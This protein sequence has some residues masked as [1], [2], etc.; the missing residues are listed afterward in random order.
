MDAHAP[1]PGGAV[2]PDAVRRKV[3]WRILPFV[4]LLYIV[5]YLDRANA[6]FAKLR[7]AAD[8]RFSEE[9][10]GL[11]F[12]IF[13]IG[14]LLLEIPGALIVERWSARKWFVRILI[15]W[16]CMSAATAFVR[17]P[18]EFY[19]ARFFLGVA[20]AGFFPGIIVHFTHWF[21][22]RDRSRALSG[23]ILGVPFSLALGAP[24]SG[25]LLGVNWL[26]L[27]GW[28]WMFIVEGAPAVVL[29][30]ATLFLLT[31]RP[32]DAAWL[33]PGE[34]EW[35]QTALDEEARA[36]ESAIRVTLWDALR[37]PQVWL[38]T[39]AIFATNTGGYAMA[40]WLPTA[41]KGVSG[42][43]DSQVLLWT[44]M[45]YS[46]GLLSV[47]LSGYSS[48]RTGE[49]KWHC[50]AGQAATAVFLSLSAIPGQPFPLVMV[51][52]CLTGFAA[53][54]WP[55]PF[56]SLPTLTLT[57]GAAAVALGLI[58]MGANLAGYLGNRNVGWLRSHGFDDRACLLFLAGCY[59]AGGILVSFLRVP[60]RRGS[61]AARS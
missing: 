16:G 55:P 44:G 13:F 33:T 41:I 8:L 21:T 45:V 52:L 2:N 35:L 12:G 10:F 27:H 6:G 25:L 15:T 9:I 26:G 18:M 38:L 61:P 20:E 23:L 49:R 32:R 34:R 22:A 4:F 50:F 51:W 19:V 42:G 1:S 11:G 48:D 59:L 37:L 47:V 14:Y 5:A 39:A 31:D 54:F 57:S 29:G 30:I 40:F 28:Q 58:N 60:P 36:K 43:T 7:M 53:Y 24:V 3:A 46:C 56:W 17:T